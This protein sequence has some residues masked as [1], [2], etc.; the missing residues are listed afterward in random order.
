MHKL[1]KHNNILTQKKQYE[2]LLILITLLVIFFF[3]IYIYYLLTILHDYQEIIE[4]LSANLVE[5]T[6]IINELRD[7][8]NLLKEYSLNKD[9]LLKEY[10]LDK[11]YLSKECHDLI[12]INVVF[13]PIVLLLELIMMK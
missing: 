11:D 7:E 13:V 2:F 12:N 1:K 4:K 10:S 6:R 9:K 3:I 8:N 5:S